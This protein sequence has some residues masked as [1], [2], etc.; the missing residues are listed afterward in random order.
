M[1]TSAPE[2]SR[3]VVRLMLMMR[4]LIKEEFA[5]TVPISD[6]NAADE[7]FAFAGRSRNTLLRQM[8]RELEQQLNVSQPDDTSPP[9]EKP[10][11]ATYRG[12]PVTQ[13]GQ[14]STLPAERPKRVYRGRTIS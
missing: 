8:A 9:Q 1:K 3:D 6:K 7:L 13:T 12:A 11:V 2:L 14:E 5:V 10:A 4:R